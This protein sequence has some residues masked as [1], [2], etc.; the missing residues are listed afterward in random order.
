[1]F[2]ADLWGPHHSRQEWV[3]ARVCLPPH[4][5]DWKS[6]SLPK[7]LTSPGAKEE[8]EKLEFEV[9]QNALRFFPL[10]H[11]GTEYVHLGKE[12]AAR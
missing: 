3:E 5:R 10:L 6:D 9:R 11:Q 8:R 12:Y 4:Q 7:A 1:M 2:L